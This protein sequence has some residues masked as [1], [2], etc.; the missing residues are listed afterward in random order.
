M[1]GA[2]FSTVVFAQYERRAARAYHALRCARQ[3]LGDGRSSAI[4]YYDNVYMNRCIH[5]ESVC[6]ERS[7]D[8]G[9]WLDSRTMLTFVFAVWS[10][11]RAL[12]WACDTGATSPEADEA[13]VLPRLRSARASSDLSTLSTT[14]TSSSQTSSSDHP[15]RSMPR[16]LTPTLHYKHATVNTILLRYINESHL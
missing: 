9:E 16:N 6:G 4:D 7:G 8:A 3:H 5:H 14:T 2:D 12:G 10:V 1:R 15:K 11:A 13:P